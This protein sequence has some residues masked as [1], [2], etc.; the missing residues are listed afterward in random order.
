MWDV[1][2]NVSVVFLMKFW[3]SGFIYLEKLSEVYRLQM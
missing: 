1:K 3:Y 2:D